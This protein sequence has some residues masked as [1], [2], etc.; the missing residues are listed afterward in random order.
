MVSNWGNR[1][2]V[3]GGTFMLWGLVAASAVYWAMKL[4][5][6]GPVVPPATAARTSAPVDPAAVARLL[7]S[8]PE[9]PAAAA[10]PS[11]ASRFSLL[12]VVAGRAQ[13]GTAALIAVDGRPPRPYRVG[14]QVDEGLVLQSVEPRRVALGATPGGPPALTLELP[15]R[16]KD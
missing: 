3:A 4:I 15:L 10:A 12:G 1:W 16:K 9:A 11:L 8:S 6:G 14:A 2:A 7:G 13:Q 5:D